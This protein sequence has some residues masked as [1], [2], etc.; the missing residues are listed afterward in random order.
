MVSMP[1]LA[2][3]KRVPL[4]A[5]WLA[6]LCVYIPMSL[7]LAFLNPVFVLGYAFLAWPLGASLDRPW[8]A[9]LV[10]LATLAAALA[11]MNFMAGAAEAVLPSTRLLLAAIAVIATAPLASSGVA[12]LL[13]RKGWNRNRARF[14]VRFAF[15]AVATVLYFQ[16]SFPETWRDWIG[17]HAT[18]ENLATL[19]GGLSLAFMGTWRMTK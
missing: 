14:L 12:A 3:L 8:K 5:V 16:D 18:E 4:V 10:T 17:E 6:V 11:A 2:W 7:S 1:R 15:L 19:A 13:E 9:S